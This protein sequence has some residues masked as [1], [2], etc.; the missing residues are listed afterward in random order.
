MTYAAKNTVI[1]T[2]F[3]MWK[4]CGKAQFRPGESLPELPPINGQ[5][6][7]KSLQN[8]QKNFFTKSTTISSVK[9]CFHVA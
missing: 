3:M 1:S 2:N 9:S 6:T 8:R 5:L 4:F 7:V